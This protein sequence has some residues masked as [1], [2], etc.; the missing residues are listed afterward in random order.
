MMTTKIDAN[1]VY[2]WSEI[3]LL[4]LPVKRF[5]KDDQGKPVVSL[6]AQNFHVKTFFEGYTF[7]LI[8]FT[9]KFQAVENNF[10]T[11]KVWRF[12]TIRNIEWEIRR[13]ES[14]IWTLKVDFH[15]HTMWDKQEAELLLLKSKL[16]DVLR[17]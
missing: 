10:S 14:Y 17:G 9:S 11:P 13:L 7:V 4:N 16:L 1:R 5:I 8:P 6:S 12:L 15:Q 2:E 3:V